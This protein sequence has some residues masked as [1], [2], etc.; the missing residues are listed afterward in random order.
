MKK[1]KNCEKNRIIMK[2]NNIKKTYTIK[3]KKDIRTIDVLSDLSIDFYSNNFYAIQGHSGS[4]K[5]TLINILGLMDSFDNGE[6]EIYGTFP[7]ELSDDELSTLRM[8]NIGFVFQGFYLN[9]TL[10]A[11][12]NV[13]VPM[14]INKN[15]DSKSRKNRAVGLLE[16]VGLRERI[17]HYPNELSGGEQQRVAVARALANNPN[18]ILADEPTGNLDEKTEKE[19]FT[20]LKSLSKNG[21]CVIV[22]SHSEHVKLYADKV[23]KIINGKLVGDIDEN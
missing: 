12:E 22:A 13:M 21:K 16:S 9:P 3:N 18:I 6:Y 2:C 7:S 1:E 17:D 20:I 11:F 8:E 14:I 4:G 15:I 23:Y 5:T 19:I 10:K